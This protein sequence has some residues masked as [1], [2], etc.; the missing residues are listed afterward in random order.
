MQAMIDDCLIMATGRLQNGLRS[1]M[2]LDLPSRI[3]TFGLLSFSCSLLGNLGK[4]PI[5]AN[6]AVAL[7]AIVACRSRSEAQLLGLCGFALFTS[8]TDIIFMASSPSF[9]GTV[10]IVLNMLLKMGAASNAYRLCG[11]ALEGS[12]SLETSDEGQAG[13]PSA[14]QAPSSLGAEEFPSFASE[15]ASEPCQ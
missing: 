5:A 12:E 9:W 10:F 1:F 11:A 7:L 13:Y 6:L 4:F 14:Y 3:E 8:V 2:Y 15:A